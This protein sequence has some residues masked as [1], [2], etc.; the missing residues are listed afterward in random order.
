MRQF[1]KVE[2][3]VVLKWPGGS[4]FNGGLQTHYTGTL[5]KRFKTNAFITL[6]LIDKNSIKENYCVEADA[7]GMS[8]GRQN[9]ANSKTVSGIKLCL[10]RFVALLIDIYNDKKLRSNRGA[11]SS[12]AKVKYRS[13]SIW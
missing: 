2:Q 12:G 10:C 4:F 8:N 6:I 7:H 11:T 9:M 13:C 3:I 1:S 5:H